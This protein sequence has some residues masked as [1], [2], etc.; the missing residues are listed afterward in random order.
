MEYIFSFFILKII[1]HTSLALVAATT[2]TTSQLGMTICPV[3]RRLASPPS[4][5]RGEFSEIFWGLGRRSGIKKKNQ[6]QDE[7][8]FVYPQPDP[9][10]FT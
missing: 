7:N 1:F 2:T 9:R 5:N 4:P 3:P 6:G 8:D 10:K